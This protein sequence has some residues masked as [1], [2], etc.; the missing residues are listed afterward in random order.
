MTTVGIYELKAKIS[1]LV[2]RAEKGEEVTITRHGRPV[3]RLLPVDLPDAEEVRRAIQEIRRLRRGNRL[4]GLTT[5]ELVE[6]GRT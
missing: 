1:E 2:A 5:K 6:E 3:A 4:R